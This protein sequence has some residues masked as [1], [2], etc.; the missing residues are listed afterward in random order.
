[1]KNLV[2]LVFVFIMSFGFNSKTN[3]MISNNTEPVVK[4]ST[5]NNNF[6]A[7]PFDITITIKSPSGK[8]PCKLH[9]HGTVNVNIHLK[10]TGYDIYVDISGGCGEAHLHVSGG[11]DI[12]SGGD[13]K[14]THLHADQP[15][16][17]KLLNSSEVLEQ[18]NSNIEKVIK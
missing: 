17:D 16:Y 6:I 13:I 12:G 1:M 11:S 7:I 5:L 4:K 9:F 2:L 10:V 3:T 14:N 15:G 18:F 8:K